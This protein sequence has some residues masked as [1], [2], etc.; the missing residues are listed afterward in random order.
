MT[1]DTIGVRKPLR[2]YCIE[3]NPLI[4]FHIEHLIEDAGHVLAGFADSF[5]Q[6]KADPA[7]THIDGALV[8]IDLADGRTGPD[9]AAW[10]KERGIPS[11]FVTGQQDVANLY[12]DRVIAVIIKPIVAEDFAG[13]IQRLERRI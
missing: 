9:A 3:D 10:L 12:A 7:A 11:I 5:S 8:D 13:K 6:L 4:V 2:I 1:S